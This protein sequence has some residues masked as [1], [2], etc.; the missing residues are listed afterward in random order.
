M[1]CQLF[2]VGQFTTNA[3]KQSHI[4]R[5]HILVSAHDQALLRITDLSNR[6]IQVY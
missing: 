2:K 3:E 1:N 4:P 5:L 6:A